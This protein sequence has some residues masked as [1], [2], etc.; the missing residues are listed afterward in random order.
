MKIDA[1]T[2]RL[3]LL[4]SKVVATLNPT[5]TDGKTLK[6]TIISDKKSMSGTVSMISKASIPP[7]P[8]IIPGSAITA[9]HFGPSIQSKEGT[10]G[11]CPDRIHAVS[12]SIARPRTPEQKPVRPM[13][14]KARTP[15][16]KASPATNFPTSVSSSSSLSKKR[17]TPDDFD[18]IEVPL[19]A[20]YVESDVENATPRTKRVVNNVQPG[21]TPVRN[22]T[23]KSFGPLSPTKT[24][25]ARRVVT[26]TGI[27]DITNSP[28]TDKAKR[29]WL[30]KIRGAPN[31]IDTSTQLGYDGRR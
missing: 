19:A 3:Q 20:R 30:G 15:E 17:R 23:R 24:A 22:A 9:R 5:D 12:S 7:V 25:P 11:S 27:A 28:R 8:E 4:Q 6:S 26:A 21:F 14:F 18:D 10:A 31:K 2:R 13:V 1:L 29:S 16:K